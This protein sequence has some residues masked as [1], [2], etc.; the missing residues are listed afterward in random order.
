[1]LI[2]VSPITYLEAIDFGFGGSQLGLSQAV[3]ENK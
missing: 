3:R 2:I 1:V